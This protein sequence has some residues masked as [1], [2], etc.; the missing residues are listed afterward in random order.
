MS[1]TS[2]N[3]SI[4]PKTSRK[5]LKLLVTI[6]QPKG[7]TIPMVQTLIKNG[8]SMELRSGSES[9]PELPEAI[10]IIEAV[11]VSLRESITTYQ[12]G[13]EDE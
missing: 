13:G 10:R 7:W 2:R 12:H 8:I 6:E 4:M 11:R 3:V 5:V 1:H 9:N